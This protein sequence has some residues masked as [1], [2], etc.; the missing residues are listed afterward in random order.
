MALNAVLFDF[1]GTLVDSEPLHFR[2][3]QQLLSTHSIEFSEQDYKQLLL[4]VPSH[5]STRLLID[6][7]QLDLSAKELQQQRAAILHARLSESSPPLMPYAQ[8]TL[9]RLKQQ[10]LALALVSASGRREIDRVLDAHAFADV[11]DTLITGDDIDRAKPNP[12]CYL[13]ALKRLDLTPMDS[14]AVED[15]RTGI[16]AA[17]AA[18]LPCLAVRN[19][20]TPEHQLAQATRTFAHLGEACDWIVSKVCPGTYP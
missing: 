9:V 15:T 7:F 1:D 14:I 2:V 19:G 20:Y 4:G 5:Q 8:Q 6:R 10:G 17:R 18:N 12:D 13:A 16:Q 11:F 3:W